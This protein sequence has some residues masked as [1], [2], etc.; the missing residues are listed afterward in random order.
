MGSRAPHPP[1]PIGSGPPRPRLLVVAVARGWR[2][3]QAHDLPRESALEPMSGL[4]LPRTR[5]QTHPSP[6]PSVLA[7]PTP[8][9]GT[10]APNPAPWGRCTGVNPTNRYC[11]HHSP[12]TTTTT[13]AATTR[14]H[15]RK[16]D[17]QQLV[18]LAIVRCHCPLQLSMAIAYAIFLPCALPWWR[19][20]QQL[21]CH[22]LTKA[23]RGS[24]AYRRSTR[25]AN[26]AFATAAA[27]GVV[28]PKNHCKMVWSLERI[29]NSVHM[30]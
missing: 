19:V 21:M 17:R 8:E 15:G 25:Y 5:H 6:S 13:T 1:G 22:M 26:Q 11:H 20:M 23:Q 12:L 7:A 30:P 16:H 14:K 24:S 27:G 18:R 2:Q 29:F 9:P 4:R 28:V 10:A 3:A